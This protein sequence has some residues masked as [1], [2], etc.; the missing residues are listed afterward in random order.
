M[1]QLSFE[2]VES[3]VDEGIKL[4]KLGKFKT[5]KCIKCKKEKEATR[6]NFTKNNECK[7]NL[8]SW[9]KECNAKRVIKERLNKKENGIC[10]HC[11]EKSLPNRSNCAYHTVCNILYN[12]N[13]IGRFE[14]LKTAKTK[15]NFVLSLLQKLEDQNYKCA[16]TGVDIALGDNAHLDH[17]REVMNG[18]SCNLENLQWVSA[19]ANLSKPRKYKE[20]SELINA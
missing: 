4:N 17:I 13:R 3:F 15:R 1:D 9:C 5:K 18:G 2:F 8:H 7:D 20:E 10:S 16:I 14:Q 6:E 11:K 19:T 12:G